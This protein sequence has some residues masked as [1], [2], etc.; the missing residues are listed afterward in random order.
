MS[1]RFGRNQ[2][3]RAREALA[4]EVAKVARAS[5]FAQHATK[6]ADERMQM[7]Q[8]CSRELDKLQGFFAEVAQRVGRES[9]LV[10]GEADANLV[11][12]DVRNF[13]AYPR[14]KYDSRRRNFSEPVSSIVKSEIMRRLEV[15]AVRD[16]FE[17]QI[18]VRCY[19]NNKTVGI[20]LSDTFLQ[21]STEQEISNRIAQE[22][23]QSLASAIKREM[24][25]PG[26]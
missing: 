8:H 22:L 3:R 19:L 13:M 5:I 24:P 9:I 18:V 21:R 15:V 1:K 2:R 26:N 7:Y 20:A 23:A 12:P 25:W 11:D 16:V 6:L 17:Q 14:P 10:G 4:V